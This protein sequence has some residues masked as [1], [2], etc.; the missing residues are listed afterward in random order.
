MTTFEEL[1]LSKQLMTAIKRLGFTEPTQ[2][3]R[4]TIP[5]CLAGK[6]VIGESAT[7]SGKTLAFGA[8]IVEKA[9]PGQGVQ[10]IILVPTRELAEQVKGDMVKIAYGKKLVILAIYGG[11]PI[12]RQITQLKSADIVIATPGRILDHL[13][14]KTIKTPNVKILVLD[15]ADRMVEMGFIDDVEKIIRACPKERQTLLF[16]ATMYGPTKKIAQ[17]YM[18]DAEIVHAEKMVD[19]DKLKQVYYDISA[20]MKKELLTV[21]IEKDHSELVMVFCN[22]RKATDMIVKV[23]KSAKIKASPIHGGLAQTKRLKTIDRFNNGGFQVLVCTDVAARGL[24]I[25]GVTHI[26]NYDIPRDPADYV[27]RIGRTARAGKKGWVVNVIAPRDHGNFSKLVKTHPEF[28]IKRA[29]NPFPKEQIEPFDVRKRYSTKDTRGGGR[30]RG[31]RQ[32]TGKRSSR[33][34]SLEKARKFGTSKSRKSFKPRSSRDDDR[35]PSRGS[36]KKPGGFRKNRDDDRRP[37][38]GGPRKPRSSRDDE[39]KPRSD[40]KPRSNRDDDRKPRSS[41][42]DER[43]P[44]SDRK[45]RSNRDDERKP[46]S[47]RKPRSNR[48]DDR[49]PRSSRDDDRK[50]RFDRKP[51]KS[52]KRRD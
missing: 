13:S 9:N 23:L 21:L 17:R 33:P 40:R 7:G 45:P 25:E 1:K 49:K 50:P 15:E 46:R 22:T 34:N 31:Q 16:S 24:H 30:S 28:N 20:P 48:D 5:L 39:R 14:R 38:A 52:F 47:D 11:V 29:D 3:Q 35:K 6:D 2:I 27:H 43:K 10:S 44:R 4:E 51:K 26:Y 19:P 12:G 42:D 36:S 32:F 41:R 18:V 8:G 37:P